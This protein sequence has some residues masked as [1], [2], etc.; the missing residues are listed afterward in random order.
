[1]KYITNDVIGISENYKIIIQIVGQRS[2]LGRIRNINSS[3]PIILYAG[4]LGGRDIC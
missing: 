4:R 1:M 2:N 3:R